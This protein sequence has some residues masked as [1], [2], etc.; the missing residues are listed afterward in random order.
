MPLQRLETRRRI[1]SPVTVRTLKRPEGRAP[2]G[3]RP[4]ACV[5]SGPE[6]GTA[7]G[8]VQ[9]IPSRG[10]KCGFVHYTV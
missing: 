8:P 7:A 6:R 10:T 4:E 1:E 3:R 5:I 2:G 9:T